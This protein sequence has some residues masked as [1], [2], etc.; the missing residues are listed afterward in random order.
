MLTDVIPESFAKLQ[1]MQEL[2]L[3]INKLSGEIPASF[4][5]NLSHLSKLGLSNNFFIGKIP[6]TI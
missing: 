2:F 4:L 1:N 6:S 3:N 5:G